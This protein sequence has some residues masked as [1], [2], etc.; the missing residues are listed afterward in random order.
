MKPAPNEVAIVIQ[1]DRIWVP[2]NS[3][4]ASPEQVLSPQW[5]GRV[6]A[7]RLAKIERGEAKF[8]TLNEIKRR[9]SNNC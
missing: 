5:H 4:A 9:F 8:L 6:V 7:E 2:E 1:C 3:L